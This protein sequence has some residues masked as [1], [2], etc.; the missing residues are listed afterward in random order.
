MGA[1]SHEPFGND[2]A[3]DWK[4]ELEA[5]KD[6]SLIEGA[7]DRVLESEED[8]VDASDAEQAVAAADVL[9]RLVTQRTENLEKLQI[10][11]AWVAKIQVKP[12]KELIRKAQQALHRIMS[13]ESEL[14]ELWQE[15]GSYDD[16]AA[17]MNSLQQQLG[18]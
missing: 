7:F 13:E 17:S 1:W 18:R 2:T 8:Y 14:F 12:R 10:V 3:A 16:W 5:A 6:L 15:S 11:D 4:Y 9:A